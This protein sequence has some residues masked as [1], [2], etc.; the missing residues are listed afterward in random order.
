MVFTQKVKE[1]L[2]FIA[3]VPAKT[4]LFKLLLCENGSN[5]IDAI[6]FSNSMFIKGG[7]VLRI[8]K[9]AAG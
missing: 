7:E 1:K 8:G 3:F 9:K 4:K 5:A 2:C 6:E